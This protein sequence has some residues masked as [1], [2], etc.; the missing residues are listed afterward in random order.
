R[1]NSTVTQV[2]TQQQRDGDFS[3]NLL[4]TM[5]TA[6]AMGRV[7]QRGQL[8]NPRSSRQITLANGTTRWIRDPYDGNIIPKT[9]FDPVALKMVAN[10]TFMPL[11]NAPGQFNATGDPINNYVDSRS[12]KSDSDQVT[13]RID[14]QFSPND[15]IYG[16]FSY[17]D[18]RQYSPG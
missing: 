13:T 14:H 18:S 7:F 2:L 16:R 3:R 6:D 5:T 15:T 8:F 10:T 11:P 4:T 12:V 9:D 17:Q 1:G